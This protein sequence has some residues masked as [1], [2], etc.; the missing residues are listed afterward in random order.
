LP[1]GFFPRRYNV[2]NHEVLPVCRYG[3]QRVPCNRVSEV[4]RVE[5][6]HVT[7]AL[8]WDVFEQL[9]GRV[10]MGV[11]DAHAIA[12]RNHLNEDVT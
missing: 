12:T 11:E 6:T 5:I 2:I 4:S 10:A 9:F 3:C 8:R 1:K 7:D